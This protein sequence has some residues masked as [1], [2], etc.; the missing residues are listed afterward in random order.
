[1][2]RSARGDKYQGMNL[3]KLK[4]VFRSAF[5]EIATAKKLRS[6]IL[7]IDDE[8]KYCGH[9]DQYSPLTADQLEIECGNRK[10]PF[11]FGK[12]AHPIEELLIVRF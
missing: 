2:N 5:S 4:S 9:D 3:D 6:R 10:L 1:M 8:I 7:E 12:D 11:K